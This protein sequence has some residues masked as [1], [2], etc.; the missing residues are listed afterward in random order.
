MKSNDPKS[1]FSSRVDTYRRYR[2]TYPTEML[3]YMK[4][5]CGLSSRSVIADI[6]SGTGIL[7]G[8]FLKLGNTVHAVEPNAEMRIAAEEAFTGFPGFHSH[9]GSAEAT[10][11]PSRS[12]DL[13]TAAQSFHWFDLE[14]ARIEFR[15][16]AKPDSCIAL[17]WNDRISEG[18][19]FAEA[20][21]SFLNEFGTDYRQV[22]HKNIEDE[23]IDTFFSPSSWKKVDFSNHQDLDYEGLK[24]RVLSSS[25]MPNTDHPDFDVMVKALQNLFQQ[26]SIDGK[27]RIGYRTVLYHNR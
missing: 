8:I 7:T 18:T 19:M 25:Y 9:D 24:G 23:C 4:N 11:L 2:P 10:N 6:G 20:Y 22:N 26:R 12:I 14:K 13:V 27:I 21:E 3:D 15:R 1:R 17:V 16:I 5:H